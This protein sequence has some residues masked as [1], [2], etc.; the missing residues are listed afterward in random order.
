MQRLEDPRSQ[1]LMVDNKLFIPQCAISARR[2]SLA[3]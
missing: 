3:L 1:M 2:A